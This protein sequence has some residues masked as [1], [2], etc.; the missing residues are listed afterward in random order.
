MADTAVLFIHGIIGTPKHFTELIPLLQQVPENFT[1]SNITLDG[2]G[3]TA[4]HFAATSMVKWKS[5]VEAEIERL[6]TTHRNL[7][8]VAHSMGCLFAIQQGIFYPERISRLLLLAAPVKI[9]VKM[10]AITNPIKV[11]FDKISP[12]DKLAQAAKTS[13]GME[14]DKRLWK[15]LKWIPRYRELFREVKVTRKMLPELK[16]P[17]VAFQ[18]AGDEMVSPKTYNIIKENKNI[19]TYLLENST[20]YLYGEEDVSK[21]LEHFRNTMIYY[22]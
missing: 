15:Y 16:V 12:K 18:S 9:G 11:Y 4:D 6:S 14:V 17:A 10:P 19:D 8:V 13:F 5:Q 7:I 1:V 20:H 2:H 22:E 21:I 3:K